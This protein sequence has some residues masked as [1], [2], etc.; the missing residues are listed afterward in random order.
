MI[1]VEIYRLLIQFSGGTAVIVAIIYL[2]KELNELLKSKTSN[3]LDKRVKDLEKIASNDM[4]EMRE[5]INHLQKEVS[6][7]KERVARIETILKMRNKE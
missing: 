6:D 5:D 1:D 4:H 7:L 2:L 3:N